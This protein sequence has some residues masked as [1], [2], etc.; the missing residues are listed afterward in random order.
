VLPSMFNTSPWMKRKSATPSPVAS[1]PA[2][3]VDKRRRARLVLR[4]LERLYPEARCHL[5]F[6]NPF[7]LLVASI[8]SAQCT[9]A[10]VNSITPRLFERYP[11]PASFARADTRELEK[12][13]YSTGFYRNKAKAIVTASAALVERYGGAVPDTVEEL[14]GLRG[15]GRKTA[16]VVVGNAYGK[17]AV[18]VDTHVRR[19]CR[20]LGL[21]DSNNPDRIEMELRRLVPEPKWTFFSNAVGDHG[22]QVCKARR[23]R[24]S[25]CALRDLCPSADRYVGRM[26]KG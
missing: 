18:I 8:L 3:D 2:A 25:E 21:V 16:N 1:P 22:R 13:I 26:D 17:P 14:T 20:R 10:R 19:V 6:R 5:R 12:E 9:D 7:E 15:V 24:C 23:P 4:R 11:D